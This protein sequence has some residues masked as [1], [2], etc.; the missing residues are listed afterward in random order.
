[1][2]DYETSSSVGSADLDDDN[3]SIASSSPDDEETFADR[4]VALKD[5]VSPQTRLALS[6]SLATTSRW[7]RWSGKVAGNLVWVVT[8]TALLIGLPMALAI[9]DEAKM[10]AQEKEMYAK[11]EGTAAVSAL[12][13]FLDTLEVEDETN[14]TNSA[15][16]R[17]RRLVFSRAAK[18]TPRSGSPRRRLRRLSLSFPSLD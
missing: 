3:V 10:Q 9:E 16:G 5:I 14:E 12:V 6:D 18:P 2:Q 13:S 4:I 1:M 15:S 8:T 11:Q 7:V 17:E